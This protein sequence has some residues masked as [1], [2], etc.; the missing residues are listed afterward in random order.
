LLQV[1]DSLTRKKQLFRPIEAG[2]ISMYVCGMTVYGDCHIG[3]A[4]S[5][6]VFDVI[7][8]YLRALEYD[9]IFVR[10]IT[11]IEDK[12]I[13]RAHE[14]GESVQA[15]TDRMIAELHR[16]ERALGVLPPDIEPRATEAMPQIIT[17]IE[18]LVASG[19]AYFQPGGDVYYEVKRFH[20]Y[21][22]LSGRD[23]EQEMAGARVA[24]DE[25]KRSPNDFVLWKQSKP[26][27]PQW[28]SPWGT[29][30]PGWH[31]ECSAMSTH[32]LGDHFDIHGGGVDLKFPHHENEIA[33]SE[34]ATGKPFANYW[35]HNGMITVDGKKMAK[36]EG[37]FHTITEVLEGHKPEAVRYF[38]LTSHY[39]SPLD[40]SEKGIRN[41]AESL[42]RLYLSLRGL[43][44]PSVP[45]SAVQTNPHVQRFCELMNDD[46]NTPGALA[47]MFDLARDLNKEKAAGKPVPEFARALKAVGAVLGLLQA[48]PEEFLRQDSSRDHALDDAAVERLIE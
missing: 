32:F 18:R 3:H 16:D 4:R 11:D 7:A 13:R 21:G 42:T 1:Y 9:V 39:A 2:K 37:N 45:L 12:I 24:V 28:D 33:Q 41:A 5:M 30:R 36:S 29:G 35:L 25:N 27:E 46:F 14:N 26:G 8:R 48:Q 38:F 10:N 22:K 23:A 44:V 6:V 17:M 19:Y 47:V 40:Y 20:D 34:A 31:I 15:L 43:D